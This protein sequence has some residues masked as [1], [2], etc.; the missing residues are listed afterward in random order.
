MFKLL[1]LYA[2]LSVVAFVCY[3]VDKRKAVVGARRISE[4]LLLSL[5]FFCGAFGGY[6][7]MWIFRHKTRKWYFHLVNLAGL[8][9]QIALAVVSYKA[10]IAW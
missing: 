8:V 10:G 6:A 3:G 5:S 4:K 7:A 9:W 1:V 2:A